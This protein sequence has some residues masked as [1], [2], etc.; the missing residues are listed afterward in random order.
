MKKIMF[1]AAMLLTM[2][3]ASCSSDDDTQQEKAKVT[4]APSRASDVAFYSNDNQLDANGNVIGAAKKTTPFYLTRA[5]GDDASDAVEVNFSINERQYPAND[6]K[7][8]IHVRSVSDVTVF[9]PTPAEYYCPADDMTIVQSHAQNVEVYGSEEHAEIDIN[10]NK[11]EL[12][13]AFA[14]NGIT[15]TTSGMNQA[16]QDYLQQTYGDGLTFE[17]C[18]YFNTEKAEADGNT[19]EVS[20]EELQ[21][22]L[23]GGTTIS[24]THTPASY[25][26]AYGLLKGNATAGE[27]EVTLMEDEQEVT[28]HVRALD[29]KVVPADLGL[30]NTDITEGTSRGHASYLYTYT[31]K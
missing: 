5:E 18:N 22:L 2:G 23:N 20:K 17:I 26:Y 13:I 29:C 10:G 21:T 27:K 19:S 14:Q 4:L 25:A 12:N 1:F 6:T 28:Y 16:V 7:L 15:I 3:F 24:F 30:F 8:S 11:V 31:R 9:I